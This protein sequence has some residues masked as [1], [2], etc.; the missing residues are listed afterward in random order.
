MRPSELLPGTP[1]VQ[2]PALLQLPLPVFQLSGDPDA[3][4]AKLAAA[5][6]AAQL[7]VLPRSPRP[8]C[9]LLALMYWLPLTPGRDSPRHSKSGARSYQAN[10]HNG[11]SRAAEPAR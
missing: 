9:L 1:A 7:S 2:L 11:S 6:V 4:P 5:S 10:T 8:R 3:R